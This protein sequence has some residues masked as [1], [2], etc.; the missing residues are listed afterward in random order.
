MCK[1]STNG[2][3]VKPVQSMRLKKFV[4]LGACKPGYHFLREAVVHWLSIFLLMVLP[5]VHR[6]KR[7][8][9]G[10]EL[11]PPAHKP[12]KTQDFDLPLSRSDILD[13]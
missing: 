6:C 11:V 13:T 10:H 8:T 9:T 4:T 12:Q 7:C 1:E 3:L 5:L 2:H